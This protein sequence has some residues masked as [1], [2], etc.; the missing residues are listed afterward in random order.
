MNSALTL[1]L[2]RLAILLL[3]LALPVFSLPSRAATPYE[4]QIGGF[5]TAILETF[6]TGEFAGRSPSNADAPLDRRVCKPADYDDLRAA[7]NDRAAFDA[8]RRRCKLAEGTLDDTHVYITAYLPHGYCETLKS[9]LEAALQEH[10]Y[11]A[12]DSYVTVEYKGSRYSSN[13]GY[14]ARQARL[15]P[16]CLGDGA[17]RI[18]APRRRGPR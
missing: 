15:E 16:A 9:A 13:R 7:A 1:P 4:A 5:M 10:V 12:E 14:L 8:F 3:V 18:S 6:I 11:G 2:Q 17:L